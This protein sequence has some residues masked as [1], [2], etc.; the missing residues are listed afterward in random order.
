[1][2]NRAASVY[3]IRWNMIGLRH[4]FGVTLVLLSAAFGPVGALR[5]DLAAAS[6]FLPSNMAGTAAAGGP[7]EPVELRGIMSTPQGTAYC[8]Y[9]T[10]KKTSA[11]VGLNES[12]NDFVVKSAD[13]AS[14]A[15]TVALQGR[16]IKLVLRTSKV[17]SAG[18][19]SAFPP[20]GNPALASSVVVNPTP[21]DEQRRLDAVASEVRRRRQEREKAAQNL[22]NGAPGA[23]APT[24]PNR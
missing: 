6:P 11:W 17:S 2:T 8:I 10:A 5:A 12:G 16:D 23:P 18:S 21:G 19:G 22:Q 15:V 14:D 24:V 4:P 7:T 20:P 13:P 1:L 3:C 9:D